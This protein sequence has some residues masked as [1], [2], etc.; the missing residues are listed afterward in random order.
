MPID[1]PTTKILNS[2]AP[3]LSLEQSF[4]LD[5]SQLAGMRQMA[6]TISK[7]T[8][9]NTVIQTVRPAVMEINTQKLESL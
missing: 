8:I 4:F 1:R 5:Q 7:M 9:S 6:G 3:N 2:T